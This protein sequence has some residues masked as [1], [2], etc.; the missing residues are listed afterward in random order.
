[1]I[2]AS[3]WR[4][5]LAVVLGAAAYDDIVPAW[6]DGD[7]QQSAQRVGRIRGRVSGASGYRV[8]VCLWALRTEKSSV[9][10]RCVD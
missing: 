8:E 4:D 10:L 6:S 9:A 5:D 2:K 7:P 3:V 1:M